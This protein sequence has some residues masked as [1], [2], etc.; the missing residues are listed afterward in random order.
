MVTFVWGLSDDAVLRTCSFYVPGLAFNVVRLKF[1]FTF[2]LG[3][4]LSRAYLTRLSL[5]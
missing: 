5:E 4:G 1:G 3:S 2:G